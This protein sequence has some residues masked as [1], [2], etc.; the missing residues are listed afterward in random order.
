MVKNMESQHSIKLLRQW[1]W[2]SKVKPGTWNTNTAFCYWYTELYWLSSC[3]HLSAHSALSFFIQVQIQILTKNIFFKILFCEHTPNT[4]YIRPK[5][6]FFFLIDTYVSFISSQPQE[7]APESRTKISLWKAL[8]KVKS[9]L[10]QEFLC[11]ATEM[12]NS[13][14]KMLKGFL[15]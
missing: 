3:S 6:D 9:I 10:I 14:Y 13:G 5:S 12:F 4:R 7:S 1:P 11:L 2:N 8:I 15:F